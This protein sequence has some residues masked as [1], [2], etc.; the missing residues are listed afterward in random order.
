MRHKLGSFWTAVIVGALLLTACQPQ[1]VEVVVTQPVEVTRQVDVEVTRQV[2]VEVTREVEVQA[3]V[4]VIRGQMRE[5]SGEITVAVEGAVPVPGAPPTKRQQAWQKI[6]GIYNQLQPEV[7]VNLIDLPAGGTGEQFCE[8]RIA[9]Q[10]MPDI[11][12]IG[13][14]DYFR[15][16]PAELAAGTVIATD[17]MPFQ[18]EINPYTGFA[19]KS[20]WLNDGLR[21]N[22]CQE[23]GLTDMW[24]CQTWW[25][26]LKAIFVNWDILN[27]YGVTEFPA[28][29]QEL[30]D[31]SE[32]INADGKYA[33]WDASFNRWQNFNNNLASMLAMDVWAQMG[34]N[35]EN[36]MERP[37]GVQPPPVPDRVINYCNQT[38]WISAQPSL[39][40]VIRQSQ[41]FV[42]ANGGGQLFF[43]PAKP[44]AGIQWMTGRAA[45]WW[46]STESQV[47]INQA[48]EDGTFLV[49]NWGLA[50]FPDFT[51]DDLIDKNV[52]ISFEGK[53]IVEYGGQGDVFA[54]TPNVRE[55]GEDANVDLMV[56]DFF[57]FLSSPLGTQRVVDEGLIPLNPIAYQNAPRPWVEAI[58]TMVPVTEEFYDGSTQ[59]PGGA[60]IGGHN[61]S[62]DPE[63]TLV[64]ILS[65]DIPFDE[66]LVTADNNV[67]REAVRRLN[68]NLAQFGLNALPAECAP[69]AP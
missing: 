30:W 54:P 12:M 52:E 22:R 63:M 20:D 66:G 7:T 47:D 14:C 48:I 19:W 62:L 33:A 11:S 39:Q 46:D 28:T 53:W 16:T 64:G 38:S 67:T 24:T 59:P 23:G 32:R 55:S 29:M 6:L 10:T 36:L 49:D 51:S 57:Q 34:A 2:E 68:D 1:T 35:P 41:R 60:I 27:E 5:L 50:Y 15:P 45:F 9:S 44:E 4:E 69:Y 43:D 21:L 18:D 31:L 42:D 65:G 58:E 8:T 3:T 40:E 37:L 56:R 26:E 25:L 17:F 13:N 61:R